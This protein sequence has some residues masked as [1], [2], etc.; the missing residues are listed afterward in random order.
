MRDEDWFWIIGLLI[1]GFLL[2]RKL[3]SEP[4]GAKEPGQPPEIVIPPP[5][6]PTHERGVPIGTTKKAALPPSRPVSAPPKSSPAAPASPAKKKGWLRGP[7]RE[8]WQKQE[9]ARLEQE[10]AEEREAKREEARQRAKEKAEREAVEKA[11]A[12]A[13]AEARMAE[14]DAKAAARA[15]QSREAEDRERQ[16]QAYVREKIPPH[17]ERDMKRF[18]AGEFMGSEQSPLT[19]VGYHVGVTAGLREKDRRE[20]LEVCFRVPIPNV[21]YA[22]YKSWGEPA[23][24][25]RLNSMM[26]HIRVQ[27][28]IRASQPKFERSVSEWEADREWL[29][30]ALSKK[31]EAFPVRWNRGAWS[32]D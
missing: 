27:A 6:E 23:T 25:Q 28:T 24:I 7:E 9:S 31:A 18:L 26:N 16:R 10:R 2:W 22:D 8:A 20:R 19:Y 1:A 29:N 11:K 21:L 17:I 5:P 4:S 32:G 30:A 13:A 14:A 15:G 3:S 12:M